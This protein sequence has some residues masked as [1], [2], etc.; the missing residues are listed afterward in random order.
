[1]YG[2]IQLALKLICRWSVQLPV[3]TDIM[4]I[5]SIKSTHTALKYNRLFNECGDILSS[6][7][8]VSRI[9]ALANTGQQI[10]TTVII[11]SQCQQPRQVFYSRVLVQLGWV[12][13][14][15]VSYYSVKQ[16]KRVTLVRCSAATRAVQVIG[17]DEGPCWFQKTGRPSVWLFMDSFI[18][19]AWKTVGF[20][21]ARMWIYLMFTECNL[22]LKRFAI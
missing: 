2:E 1:M 4:G 11:S 13:Y 15:K 12:A 21:R 6:R 22:S 14:L 19:S 3:Y 17:Q 9:A 20:H 10:C 8:V 18:P 5:Y 7:A 16:I